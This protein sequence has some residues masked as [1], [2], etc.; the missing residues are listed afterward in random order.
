MCPLLEELIHQVGL[1]AT[2]CPSSHFLL[3]LE[4]LQ[5]SFG[6]FTILLPREERSYGWLPLG[7]F[8]LFANFDCDLSNWFSFFLC[9][10]FL[11]CTLWA[12]FGSYHP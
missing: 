2:V 7:I 12:F 10:V 6:T 9:P 11:S 1:G 5:W 3:L 4:N 8:V